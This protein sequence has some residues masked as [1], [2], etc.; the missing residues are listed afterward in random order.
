MDTFLS[1]GDGSG[2]SSI[3]NARMLLHSVLEVVESS[4]GSLNDVNGAS[5]LQEG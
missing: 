5:S 3:D 2:M 1:M 4:E